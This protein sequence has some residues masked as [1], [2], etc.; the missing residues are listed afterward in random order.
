M[1][2]RQIKSSLIA[3]VLPTGYN[4]EAESFNVT[5]EQPVE[6]TTPAGALKY[7]R[8]TGSGTPTMTVD[9]SGYATSTGTVAAHGPGFGVM[10]LTNGD[11]GAAATFT[12]DTGTYITGS[13]VVKRI[14]LSVARKV[15][16]ARVSFQLVNAGD[17]TVT[18]ATA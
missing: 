18:W 1:A 7:S 12:Y 5:E 16:G 9:V 11:F 14:T 17:P 10:A 6:D 4:C 3:V 2:R 15:P 8:H 13:F